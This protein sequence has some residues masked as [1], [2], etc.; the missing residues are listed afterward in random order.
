MPYSLSAV[1]SKAL[2][3]VTLGLSLAGF[4]L[5]IPH[6]NCKV[7]KSNDINDLFVACEKHFSIKDCQS[8]FDYAWGQGKMQ[9]FNTEHQFF[10]FGR[11][12]FTWWTDDKN[13]FSKASKDDMTTVL[14]R[15]DNFCH[16]TSQSGGPKRAVWAGA[17]DDS[18][19]TLQIDILD[20]PNLRR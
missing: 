4:V 9:Y 7:D 19:A 15:I 12:K 2:C 13:G 8:E 10:T 20:S 18:Y 17:I 14:K 5:S 16:T 6:K 3:F 1:T 11:C